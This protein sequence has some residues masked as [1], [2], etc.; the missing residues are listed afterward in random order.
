MSQVETI[1]A[2]H[3]EGKFLSF[4]LGKE[5]YGVDILRVQEIKGW[6]EVRGL[7]DTPE[8]VKG[9]L[10]LRGV[11]VPIIDLRTRNP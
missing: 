4:N 2:S 3:N 8:Y 7:P 1:L 9:V 6:E 10:D 5:D 11:I